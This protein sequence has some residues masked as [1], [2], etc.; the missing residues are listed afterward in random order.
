MLSRQ[1]T[2]WQSNTNPFSIALYEVAGAP[3][4]IIGLRGILPLMEAP[5]SK[6]DD[7]WRELL[8]DIYA[9]ELAALEP[10]APPADSL[11]A[12]PESQD[13]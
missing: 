8:A 3:F 5:L 13:S 2:G 1:S 11:P 10:L 7:Q 4:T 12:A 6:T 9:A